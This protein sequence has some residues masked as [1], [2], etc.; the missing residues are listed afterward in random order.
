LLQLA[1]ARQE[2]QN[3]ALS[4]YY[5]GAILNRMKHYDEALISLDAALAEAPD[6]I[7][8]REERGESLWQV[9][10]KDEAVSAWADAVR[11]NPNLPLANY[12]LAGAA[13]SNDQAAARYENQA[14]MFVPDDAAFQYMVGLRLENLRFS[15]LAEKHFRRAAQLDPQF[16]AR[17]NLDLLN[18]F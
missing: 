7:L 17:R 4:L 3:K 6:L 8:A 10:R 2:G 13:A 11:Q 12:F 16:R 1:S 15:T 14:D 18:R 5:R 9:G